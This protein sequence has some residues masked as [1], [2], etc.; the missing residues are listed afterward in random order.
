MDNKPYNLPSLI[1]YK[2][3]HS[4]FFPLYIGLINPVI[5]LFPSYIYSST[6]VSLF[7][8]LHINPTYIK[9]VLFVVQL[10][11]KITTCYDLITKEESNLKD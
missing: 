2:N 11:I 4:K 1:T 3:F 5:V 9:V 10:S 7:Y 6:H 8:T